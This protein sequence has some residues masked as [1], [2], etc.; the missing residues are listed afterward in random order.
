ML[1]PVFIRSEQPDATPKAYSDKPSY[2]GVTIV[3][4]GLNENGTV[5]WARVERSSKKELDAKA[6]AAV[7]GWVFKPATKNGV[8][9]PVRLATEVTFRLY[10]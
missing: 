5:D 4:F 8:P 1:P 10:K 6:L 2:E 9:V 7:A 3:E